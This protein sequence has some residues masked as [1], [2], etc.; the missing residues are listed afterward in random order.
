VDAAGRPGWRIVHNHISNFTKAK[1]TS[2]ARGD[3]A[4][5]GLSIE[6]RVTLGDVYA[7]VQYIVRYAPNAPYRLGVHPQEIPAIY[8]ARGIAAKAYRPG[9]AERNVCVR[10]TAAC[11]VS[12][13]LPRDGSWWGVCDASGAHCLTV[14]TFDGGVI[15]RDTIERTPDGYGTLTAA[16]DF[17]LVPGLE[18]SFTVYL[19]PYRFDRVIEGKSIADRIDALRLR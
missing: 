14:A 18:K 7:K 19:F 5:P 1:T 15:T 12:R 2:Y 16:G 4:F 10:G 8:T 9:E 11:E 17:A 3:G 6:Q 13:R